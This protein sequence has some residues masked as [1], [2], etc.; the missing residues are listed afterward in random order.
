MKKV[1]VLLIAILA[2]SGS[3]WG[4]SVLDLE[5]VLSFADD[6]NAMKPQSVENRYSAGRFTSDIDDYLDVNY[7]DPSIGTF[8]FLG[9][10]PMGANVAT[11]DTPF[12]EDI[13]YQLSIGF[14]KSYNGLYLGGYYGGDLVN[15]NGTSGKAGKAGKEVTSSEADWYNNLALIFGIRGIAFRFDLA[16]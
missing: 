10:H 1:I 16:G 15:A 5:K 12:L 6:F 2:V 7:H 13:N 14:A 9:G 4:Q 3:V 11:N 8:V